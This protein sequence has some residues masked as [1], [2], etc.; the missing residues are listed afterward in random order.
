MLE[1]GSEPT[2]YMKDV[3]RTFDHFAKVLGNKPGSDLTA[4]DFAKWRQW[5]TREQTKR[6]VTAKWHNDQHKYIKTIFNTVRTERPS[7]TF[8]DGLTEWQVLSR[9]IKSR[10]KYVPKSHNK[11]PIPV[12]VFHAVLKVAEQ[13]AG[14]TLDLDTSTQSERGKK[15][16]AIARRHRGLTAYAMF[17]LAANCGLDNAD[18]AT[19]TWDHIKN[20]DGEL[21]Y[22]DM[23]R[24]KI[25]NRFR[26]ETD[27]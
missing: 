25:K 17:K 24:A 14:E 20:L 3:K 5:V 22:L 19:V 4:D 11:Q 8:P 23:S 12:D 2:Q 9:R 16:C 13:W 6:K 15:R 21:P 18:T 27:R 7:W 26:V 10:T 1:S